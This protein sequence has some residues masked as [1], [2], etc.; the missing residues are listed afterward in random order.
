M[1][2]ASGQKRSLKW[3]KW[4]QRK[5]SASLIAPKVALPR[6]SRQFFVRKCNGRPDADRLVPGRILRLE[7]FGELPAGDVGRYAF[8]LGFRGARLNRAQYLAIGADDRGIGHVVPVRADYV[9]GFQAL[10]GIEACEPVP[11]ARLG[12]CERREDV[13]HREVA[14]KEHVVALHEEHRVAERVG[15]PDPYHAD[16]D[17]AE[18]DGLFL[19]VDFVGLAE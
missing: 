16:A 17:A 18:V 19:L 13:L 5:I 2:F 15:R 3:V 10:E 12:H 6:F 11:H 14:G 7:L 8:T 9:R 1:T 4:G